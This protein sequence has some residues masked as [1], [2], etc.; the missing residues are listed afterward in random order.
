MVFHT[1]YLIKVSLFSV[2]YQ[3]SYNTIL[4]SWQIV[5]KFLIQEACAHS[6]NSEKNIWLLNESFVL[7]EVFTEAQNYTQCFTFIMR[8]V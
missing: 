5:R 3:K 1:V 4:N 7:W 2:K 8:V 6:E